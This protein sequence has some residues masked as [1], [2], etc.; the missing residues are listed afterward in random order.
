VTDVKG[1]GDVPIRS[2]GTRTIYVKDI[3]AVEDSADIQ[4]GYALVNG[5]ETV[6]IPVTKRAEAST[7]SVVNLVKANLGKFQAVLP[8][9]VKVSYV[10]DQSP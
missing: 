10:F 6:Y 9:G 7:L 4:A 3:G 5:H 1:L 2:D 8:E